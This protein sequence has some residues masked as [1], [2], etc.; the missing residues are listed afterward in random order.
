M[1]RKERPEII[2]RPAQFATGLTYCQ[3]GG[4]VW[5]EP[6]P[7]GLRKDPAMARWAYRNG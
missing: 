7:P 3:Q 6:T 2:R 5:Y 1:D 4:R